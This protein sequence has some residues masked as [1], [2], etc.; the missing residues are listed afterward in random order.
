MSIKTDNML[1]IK[2]LLHWE[3]NM[4]AG[5]LKISLFSLLL[6]IA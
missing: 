5:Y 1:H 3:V 4:G 6:N 2:V